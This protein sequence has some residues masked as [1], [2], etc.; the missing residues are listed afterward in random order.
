[1]KELIMETTAAKIEFH[2]RYWNNVS[3]EGMPGL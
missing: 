3:D 1:M 2:E